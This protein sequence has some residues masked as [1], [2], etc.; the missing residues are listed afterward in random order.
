VETTASGVQHDALQ[1]ALGGHYGLERD[2]G[3]GDMAT[4]WLARDLR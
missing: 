2:L 3:R 4:V 1:A